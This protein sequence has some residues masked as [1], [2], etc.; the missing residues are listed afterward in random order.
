MWRRLPVSRLS[1]VAWT[2]KT[3]RTTCACEQ[4]TTPRLCK[5]AKRWRWVNRKCSEILAIQCNFS[6]TLNV[7]VKITSKCF[8]QINT[9]I[10]RQ[11]TT[12]KTLLMGRNW[13]EHIWIKGRGHVYDLKW[14]WNTIEILKW[15]YLLELWYICKPQEFK[16]E[17]PWWPF[18]QWPSW[19]T[20]CDCA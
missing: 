3:T 15:S 12:K 13:T 6:Y 16:L 9:L 2:V 14:S 1:T 11:A 17:G 18:H 4:R 19:K 8:T 20:M 10:T 7:T 5:R